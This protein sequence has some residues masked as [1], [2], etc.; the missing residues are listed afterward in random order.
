MV[1]CLAVIVSRRFGGEASNAEIEKVKL[2]ILNCKL[3]TELLPPS[4]PGYYL[5]P[6]RCFGTK[7]GVRS[8]HQQPHKP[9][10]HSPRHVEH[11]LHR[12]R[13]ERGD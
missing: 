2:T 12:R 7:R 4:R 11:G 6:S 13:L 3:Q 10:G 8:P 5:A 9:T 1:G